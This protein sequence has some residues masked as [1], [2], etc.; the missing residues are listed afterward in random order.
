MEATCFSESSVDAQRTTR[1]Y[2]PEDGTFHNHRC[3]N[4]KSYT[5][6]LMLKQVV[7]VGLVTTV[8]LRDRIP[9]INSAK[10]LTQLSVLE[11]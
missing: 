6:V 2:I 11:V 10:S 3:E 1:S 8:L 5:E 7:Y 4:L 9:C